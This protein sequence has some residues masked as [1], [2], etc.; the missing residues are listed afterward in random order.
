MTQGLVTGCFQPLNFFKNIPQEFPNPYSHKPHSLAIEAADALQIYLNKTGITKTLQSTDQGKMFGILVVKSSNDEI[1]YLAAFS[2]MLI[3]Q[4][5]HEGFVPPVFELSFRTDLLLK[6][7]SAVHSLS[8][9]ISELQHSQMYLQLSQELKTTRQE[10]K[11]AL[12][13]FEQKLEQK[14]ICR[15]HRRE[16][17]QQSGDNTLVMQLSFESQM[18]RRSRKT[19]RKNL[20]HKI[21]KSEQALKQI[22][23]RIEALQ[24]ERSILSKRLQK[25]LFAGYSLTNA[26][27]DVRLLSTFY[28]DN[29]PPSGAGDC[30]APKLLN[31]A[32][33][34]SY[35][36]LAM[37]EFWIGAD[38][39]EGVRH[40]GHYYPPC[41][42]RCRPILSYMLQGL[43]VE[44]EPSRLVKGA[45]PQ[46]VMEDDQIVVVNKPS[47]LLSIPGK[48][49]EESVYSWLRDRY[50]DV[51]GPL[52]VHR[53][54][55]STS[56]LLIAAKSSNA[57]KKLQV[58]FIQRKIK[59]RYVALLSNQMKTKGGTIDLPLRVDLQDRPR[60]MVCYEHGKPSVTKW[61]L[62]SNMDDGSRIHFYPITGRTHQLRIHAAHKFGLQAPIVGDEL[63]GDKQGRRLMLHA[64]QLEFRHP[65][66]DEWILIEAPAPF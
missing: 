39:K 59:K 18:D 44:N 12:L 40:H 47:G 21:R 65:C 6:G 7:E 11:E 52:L 50:T 36:P 15:H 25:K 43:E 32:Y 33:K 23:D 5:V 58:Q 57:H 62:I 37:A 51:S 31:Y 35:R 19:L 2:G 29:Q 61:E 60:Q 20:Q 1:G 17:A 14:K 49:T 22:N 63:Y 10:S 13:Q 9:R 66:T 41:R 55:M 45:I 30:A 28:G 16:I 24:L 34:N 56:G 42:G 64:E 26:K 27:E 48:I 3:G 8:D 53:L 4:W 46:V 54:D 38:P